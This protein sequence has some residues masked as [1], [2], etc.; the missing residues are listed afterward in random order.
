MAPPKPKTRRAQKKVQ[1]K[2]DEHLG[3][4][5]ANAGSSSSPKRPSPKKSSPRK[6]L[7]PAGSSTN[8]SDVEDSKNLRFHERS[9]TESSEDSEEGSGAKKSSPEI[10]DLSVDEPGQSPP[11]T[12]KSKLK[13]IAASDEGSGSDEFHGAMVKKRQNKRR[14]VSPPSGSDNSDASDLPPPPR[15][16]RLVRGR[17]N[18][19]VKGSNSAT[20]EEDLLKEVDS[21]RRWSHVSVLLPHKINITLL[22]YTGII[23]D[24]TR[25]SKKVSGFALGL[26]KLKRESKSCPFKSSEASSYPWCCFRCKAGEQVVIQVRIRVE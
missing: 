10:I 9:T 17:P 2:L 21:N 20:E 18:A 19:A 1:T 8:D 5:K 4:S 15:R 3:R 14:K 12:Q 24:N 11:K 26:D 16:R 22:A 6:R 13:E 7:L 23:K 25:I